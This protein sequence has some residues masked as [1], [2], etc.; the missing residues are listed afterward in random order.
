M[1][2]NWLRDVTVVLGVGD[3]N[4]GLFI[5]FATMTYGWVKVY[6]YDLLEA[7]SD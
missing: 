6:E 7:N 3:K 1:L 4:S 2:T 5:R